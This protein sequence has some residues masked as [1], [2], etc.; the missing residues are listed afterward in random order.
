MALFEWVERVELD[1]GRTLVV[2]Y[3]GERHGWGCYIPGD[4]KRPTVAELPAEAIVE[5]LG[6]SP[7]DP[8]AWVLELSARRQREL[9]EAPRHACACCGYLTLLNPGRYETCPVCRW[10]DDPAVEWDGPDAHSGGPNHI[11]LNEGR[12]NFA[13]F[14]A[15]TERRKEFARGPRPDERPT[16]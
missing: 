13:R 11:S 14:G 7:G 4:T 5:H 6:Y 1:D 16:P 10:E 3:R 2:E 12:A 9:S 8:P 15:S